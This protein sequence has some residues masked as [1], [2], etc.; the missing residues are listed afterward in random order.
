MQVRI[1][2]EDTEKIKSMLRRYRKEDLEF[3][4]L[5]DHFNLKLKREQI[6]KE[7]VI[8]NILKP[9]NLVFVGVSESKN[10]NY[11]YVYDLY[12][13]LGR[14]RIF[15]IPV[16]MK[17]KSLYLITIFKIRSRMQNEAIKYY[18]K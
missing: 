2:K 10:P 5:N 13:K 15:K 16:S 18:Q 14:R 12:F 8:K 9:D 17:P 1:R 4:E 7:E 11:K 3:N 6:N